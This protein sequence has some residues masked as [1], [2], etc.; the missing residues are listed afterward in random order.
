MANAS[1]NKRPQAEDASEK[2]DG[3][4]IGQGTED[5]AED[6]SENHASESST[7]QDRPEGRVVEIFVGISMFLITAALCFVLTRPLLFGGGAPT[8]SESGAV[9]GAPTVSV[10]DVI[11]L[12]GVL[13]TGLFVFMTF[14]IDRGARYEAQAAAQEAIRQ[15]REEA[16][17]TAKLE[18][19]AAAQ[20]AIHQA[21]EEAKTTAKLEAQAAAQEA[22]RQAR[23]E[24]KTTAKLI[25]EEEARAIAQIAEEEAR[26]VAIEEVERRWRAGGK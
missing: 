22:I 19:Q 26:K 17:T 4:L 7:R 15:A 8:V 18:A 16:K 14:R 21:R 10:P 12:F 1:T 9:G 11:T 20:E 25:A 6:A 23:E 3:D 2:P 24:A 5:Q 13:I